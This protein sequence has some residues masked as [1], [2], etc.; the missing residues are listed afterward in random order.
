[1][2]WLGDYIAG[3]VREHV[4]AE[5]A[6]ALASKGITS[7]FV[8]SLVKKEVE[9]HAVIVQLAQVRAEQASIVKFVEAVREVAKDAHV[10]ARE[11]RDQV[12]ECRED[13]THLAETCE[14]L[15]AECQ[16]ILDPQ[17]HA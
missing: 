5:L 1:M 7:E 3:I 4:T 15:A 16:K 11:C 17:V 8:A 12:K 10:S 13:T 9:R 14:K 2:R 6:K